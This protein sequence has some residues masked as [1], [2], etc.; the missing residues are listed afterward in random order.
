MPIGKTGWGVLHHACQFRSALFLVID[1]KV[2]LRKPGQSGDACES[3]G[4]VNDW[5][6]GLALL[7]SRRGVCV[8]GGR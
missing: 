5:I 8:S 6:L 7:V 1:R 4:E 3:G 2:A